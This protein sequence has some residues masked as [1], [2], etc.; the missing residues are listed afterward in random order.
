MPV[1][2]LASMYWIEGAVALSRVYVSLIQSNLG[3]GHHGNFE[4]V[5]VEGE[6]LWYWYRDNT[7]ADLP[8]TPDNSD[9]R[10]P[11]IREQRVTGDQDKVAGSGCLIQSTPSAGVRGNFEV[12][13]PLRLATGAVELRHFYRDNNATDL[14]WIRGQRVTGDQ[15]KVAGSGC[16]IQSTPS[17]GVRGNFEVV[18]P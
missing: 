2:V 17:A 14:P 11:W 6:Q 1:P 13:V 5:I 18:V 12:V 9:T 7:N 15:D 8:W 3:R 16:L 10:L 4:T